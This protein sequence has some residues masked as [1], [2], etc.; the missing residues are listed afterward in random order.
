MKKKALLLLMVFILLI[1]SGISPQFAYSE[2]AQTGRYIVIFKDALKGKATLD[3]Q[4]IHPVEQFRSIPGYV[5][6]LNEAQLALWANDDNIESLEPDYQI[7]ALGITLSSESVTGVTYS[8]VDEA[9]YRLTSTP[10]SSMNILKDQMQSLPTSNGTRLNRFPVALLGTGISNTLTLSPMDGISFVGGESY[11]D[12]YGLGNQ[13]AAQLTELNDQASSLSPFIDLYAAKVLH[14][15]GVGYLSDAVRGLEWAIKQHVGL[16]AAVFHLPEDS[17]AWNKVAQMAEDNGIVLVGDSSSDPLLPSAN[18]QSVP[19]NSSVDQSASDVNS[20]VTESVYKE[21]LLDQQSIIFNSTGLGNRVIQT[22]LYRNQNPG[23]TPSELM[24]LVQGEV[25]SIDEINEEQASEDTDDSLLMVQ[26]T[27]LAANGDNAVGVAARTSLLSEGSSESSPTVLTIELIKSEFN[28]TTDFIQAELNQGLTLEEINSALGKAQV[29]G[30]SYPQAKASLYKQATNGSSTATSDITNE[31]ANQPLPMP[32]V[33]PSQS[34]GDHQ[35]GQ[36]GQNGGS[37]PGNEGVTKLNLPNLKNNEAPFKVSLAGE[38]VSPLSGA[39]SLAQSD[40]SLPGRGGLSFTLQRTYDS[41]ASQLNEP[42]LGFSGSYSYYV[43]F[44]VDIYRSYLT[45]YLTQYYDVFWV[46]YNC[47]TGKEVANG[48]QGSGPTL[49]SS[50][51][52]YTDFVRARNT[53][54]SF[55]DTVAHACGSIKDEPD[56]KYIL[57]TVYQGNNTDSSYGTPSYVGSDTDYSM[58]YTSYVEANNVKATIIPGVTYDASTP[59]GSESSGYYV[60]SYQFSSN[61]NATVKDLLTSGS[62]YNTIATPAEEK[63]FPIGKGWSWNIPYLEQKNGAWRVN[64]PGQ[65]SYEVNGSTL[66]DYPW[67][68]LSFA[69]DTNVNVNATQSSYVLK[70]IQGT[71]HYFDATG[72]LIQIS[73]A[74]GNAIRFLYTNVSPYGL[75]LTSVQD[76]IGNAITIAYSAGK[77]TLTQGNKT[78]VYTKTAVNGKEMLASVTDPAGRLTTFDYNI[79]EAQFNLVGTVPDTSNP[80]ALLTGITFPTGARTEYTYEPTPVTRSISSGMVNQA[81]RLQSRKDVVSYSNGSKEE[82]N[83]SS[84]AYNGD[85]ASSSGSYSFSTKL[86]NGITESIFDYKKLTDS[87]SS[88]SYYLTK[89]SQKGDNIEHISEYTYDE[90]RKRPAPVTTKSYSRNSITSATSA[91]AQVSKQYDDYGN[92]T[93]VTDPLGTTSTFIFDNSTHLLSAVIEPITSSLSRYTQYSRNAQGYATEVIARENNASGTILRQTQMSYDSYGNVIETRSKDVNRDAVSRYE[94]SSVYNSAFLTKITSFFTDVNGYAKSQAVSGEYDRTSGNILKSIDGNGKGISYQYDLLNRVRVVTQPDA[95]TVKVDYDDVA[96]Q[97]I[98]TNEAG[99]R[100][101]SKYNPVGLQ[102]EQGLYEGGVY[103]K[104]SRTGYDAAGRAL[105]TEDADGNRTTFTY[106]PFSRTTSTTFS[107]GSQNLAQYDDIASIATSFDGEGIVTR[108][109][110]DLLGRTVQTEEGVNG[111]F[112]IQGKVA[113]D[114]AGNVTT[115]WDANGNPT[116]YTYD[117]LGQVTSSTTP[118]K[119]TYRFAYDRLGNLTQQID[120]GSNIKTKQYD[121]L[122]RLIRQTD[123]LGN[124]ATLEY[125]GNGNRIKMIDRNGTTFSYTYS[126]R[127]MLLSKTGANSSVTYTYNPDGARSSMKDSTG[128]T[129]YDYT[130]LGQLK[131]VTYPDGQ[132]LTST[133]DNKGNR[134][135]MTAPFSA[136]ANYSYDGLNRLTTVNVN[137]K[138]EASYTYKKNSLLSSTTLGN[139]MTDTRSYTGMNLTAILQQKADGTNTNAYAYGYDLNRN[140]LSRKTNG[141]SDAF[142]YDANSRI[143]TSSLFSEQYAYDGRSNRQTLISDRT[144]N[145][146]EVSYE[147]DEWDR[148]TKAVRDNK[149]VSYKYNGDDLLV[150]RSEGSTTTRYYYDGVNIVAEATLVNGQ[151]VAKAAYLRGNQLIARYGADG[152]KSYYQFNGHGDVTELRDG[153]GNVQNSYSYDIWG[154]PVVQTEAVDNLFRYSGEYLDKATSLQY[155]RARWYDPDMG[156]FLNEDTYEGQEDSPQSLNLYS[157]VI[158]NPLIYTDPSGHKA[159]LIHGTWSDGN[160]WSPEFIKYV[161]GLFKESSDKLIWTGDN[162]NKA[163]SDAADQFLTEVYNWHLKNPDDPIRLIGHSH[164][165]NVAILLANLL[166]EKGMKVETL[167]TIATPVREYQLKADVGQHI[168]LYNRGDGVQINGGSIWRLGQAPKRTFKNAE[169]V[170]VKISIWRLLDFRPIDSHSIMHSNIKVWKKYIEPLLKK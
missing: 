84:L 16:V 32:S 137:N 27:S 124:N 122:N 65:G 14:D 142:G 131:K 107:D 17:F 86:A 61:P 105:W 76:D 53:P 126:S 98:Q 13:L 116:S 46:K 140:M 74:Y 97:V 18:S 81:Y 146:S 111:T 4:N 150:E 101:V 96:N 155:L 166:A 66:K 39:L 158:N 1:Q 70:S 48:R 165:G 3:Q 51:S 34:G 72:N 128:T 78:V 159:W 6:E 119:E 102:T 99:L 127:N 75:V 69:N 163:R 7:S 151:P 125:D 62:Y 161:E 132:T 38:T 5:V 94:Y 92:V 35:S 108:T 22:I 168:H 56:R 147:Y 47:T 87:S 143:S 109:T 77:V 95:T 50:F 89:S 123:Q 30:T 24:R 93:S 68:D 136:T 20:S 60:D 80:Y 37:N 52:S 100:S 49:N 33:L 83:P 141:T 43:S 157:Y 57:K 9:V 36:T 31:T 148:L 42:D 63:R 41:S 29:D 153:S 135:S 138:I 71:K 10:L 79:K 54:Q 8:S 170:E 2:G 134:I 55:T 130:E 120:P 11:A 152:T 115:Q 25:A 129:K 45:Y 167:I 139:G 106:D 112:T 64:L 164:G 19:E 149:N 21:A 160:T 118:M 114:A 82:F 23:L 28:V 73:D 58:L 44:N 26:T 12:G 15:N 85:M 162:T 133:Y 88:P 90:A 144:P 103:K 67:Q 59:K 117:A 169:N 145:L 110:L 121:E 113:Y 154:N 156:R 40:L 104:K 91:P